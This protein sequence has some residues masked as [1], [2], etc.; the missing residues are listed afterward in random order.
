MKA[1]LIA[2]AIGIVLLAGVAYGLYDVF[3][4]LAATLSK[5]LGGGM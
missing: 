2:I 1:E 3:H 5:P 4:Q